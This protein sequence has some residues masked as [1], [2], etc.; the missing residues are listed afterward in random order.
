MEKDLPGQSKGVIWRFKK[1]KTERPY[2]ICVP[3]EI[4]PEIWNCMQSLFGKMIPGDR[5]EPT[6]KSETG[7]EEKPI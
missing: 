7:K 6:G 1:V 5:N 3:P 4:E 2:L